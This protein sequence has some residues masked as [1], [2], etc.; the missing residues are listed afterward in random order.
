MRPCRIEGIGALAGRFAAML[1]DQFGVLHDGRAAFPGALDAVRR[2]RDAGLRLAVLSNSGKRAAANAARL[3]ELG[4]AAELFDAVITSGE[5]CRQ[6]LLEDLASGRLAAGTPVH[7]IA[8]APEASPLEGVEL[9]RARRPEEAALVLIAGRDPRG[10]A[11][12]T[13]LAPLLPLARRGIPCLCANPDRT[14]YGPAGPM[15]GPGALAEAYGAA[16]GPVRMVGKP[17]PEIFRAALAALGGPAPERTLMVGDS[18]SHDTAGAV[19]L[20]LS[21]LL[22]ESGVQAA[23]GE[24]PTADFVAASFVW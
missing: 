13:E 19:A 1:L 9:T 15:P 21:T 5:L 3:A 16:G 18:P 14:I 7:L 20:G 2:L 23:A 10:P 12:D 24:G 11:L 22:I 8:S 6:L 17:R 4:F